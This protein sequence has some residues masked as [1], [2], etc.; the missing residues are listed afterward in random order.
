MKVSWNDHGDWLEI[1]VSGLLDNDSAEPLSQQMNEL[2]RGGHH[3]LMLNLS[4]VSY[5]SS[6]GIST[7][8]KTHKQ[9]VAIR[10][11]FAV[12]EPSLAVA[13]V[14]RLTRLDQILVRDA[15]AAQVRNPYSST[16]LVMS[17]DDITTFADD[18]VRGTTY[19]LGVS[20]PLRLKRHGDPQRLKERAVSVGE[21][22]VLNCD[23][24]SFAL[25]LGALGGDLAESHDRMGEFLA[26]GGATAHQPTGGHRAADFQME[27]GDFVPQ[28]QA[29]YA[30]QFSGEFSHL[31]RFRGRQE[32]ARVPL[33]V[34]L[35]K[36]LTALNGSTLGFVLVG[37]SAGLVGTSLKRSPLSDSSAEADR[38]MFEHPSVRDWLSYAPER[39]HDRTLV[40]CVGV[41]GN[42]AKVPS[43][44]RPWLRPLGV[45]D[46][47]QGHVHAG[48]F[49]YRPL[50]RGFLELAPTVRSMFESESLQAVLHLLHDRRPITGA[51]ESEFTGGACWF[52]AIGS[53]E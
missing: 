21:G 36:M 41:I 40:A 52:G 33:S 17:A 28:V 48:V 8:L 9:L 34:I 31:M 38:G 30:L 19:S 32:S 37:E 6:A 4:D 20:E 44:L 43:S 16:M 49:G 39:V 24:N 47:L 12:C 1:R 2:I 25:G 35:Q 50:K 7:L 10:G 46:S 42:S 3:R 26:I 22:N 11:F 45:E 5:L 51:G 53:E 29:L 14:L 13:E 15:D 18:G 23:K 27:V